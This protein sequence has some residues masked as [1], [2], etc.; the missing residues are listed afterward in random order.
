LK[1]A[2]VE[3]HCRQ[4]QEV[5]HLHPLDWEAAKVGMANEAAHGSHPRQL[6]EQHHAEHHRAYQLHWSQAQTL[7]SLHPQRS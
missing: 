5:H 3:P 4:E 1:L 2:Y 7:A 6:L